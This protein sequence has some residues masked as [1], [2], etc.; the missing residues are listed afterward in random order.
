LRFS[1]THGYNWI[2]LRIFHTPTQ[3]PTNLPYTIA[4]AQSAKKL[5]LRFLL[6]YHYSDTWADPGKQFIPKAWEGIV[7]EAAYNR[8][9]GNYRAKPA[10][11]PES[12]EG[13]MQFWEEV[14][15]IVQATPDGRGIGVFWWEP[16]VGGCRVGRGFFDKD[17]NALPVITVFD[18]FTRH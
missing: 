11:F 7:V 2:R 3:I 17:G 8:T 13:Q 16:A 4:R 18:K 12:P 14:N 9:P 6:D 1:A 10:P 15:R 5:G